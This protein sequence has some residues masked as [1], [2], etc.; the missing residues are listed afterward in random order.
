MYTH[1]DG[2]WHLTSDIYQQYTTTRYEDIHEDIVLH[3]LIVFPY[4]RSLSRILRGKIEIC[5]PKALF[6]DMGISG[7]EDVLVVPG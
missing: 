5:P 3:R 2:M 6:D 7:V 4:T 1:H